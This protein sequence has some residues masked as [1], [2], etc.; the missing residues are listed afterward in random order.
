MQVR[1]A[2]REKAGHIA[3]TAGNTK[4]ITGGQCVNEFEFPGGFESTVVSSG[5]LSLKFAEYDLT[6][7]SGVEDTP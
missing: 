5:R 1:C 6:Q 7:Y 3:H 4:C 2:A